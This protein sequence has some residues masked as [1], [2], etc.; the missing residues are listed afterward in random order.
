MR[1]NNLISFKQGGYGNGTGRFPVQRQTQPGQSMSSVR[2]LASPGTPPRQSP[3]PPEAAFPPPASPTTGGYQNQ[4]QYQQM[5]L[6][7]A[8][9][10]PSA[11]T[12]L[13]GE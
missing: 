11:T 6:Q 13:P 4:G 12:Q 1:E 2:S 8:V 3:F 7:R 9:S 5:R 10:A